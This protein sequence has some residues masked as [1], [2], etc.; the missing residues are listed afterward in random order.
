MP[1]ERKAGKITNL[2]ELWG[3][4]T[5]AILTEY[6][7]MTVAE[8]TRLRRELR[9][10]GTEYHVTKN[11]L[12]LRA[13]NQLGYTGLDEALAGPTAVAF[14]KED[15]AGGSKV[16]LDFARNNKTIVVKQAI[17]NGKLLQGDR[18]E[19]IS[20]IPPRAELISTMLGSL[21]APPRNLVNVL[22][23]PTRNLVNVLDA[24]RKQKEEAGAS[25]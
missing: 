19:A 20:K 12:L 24:I 22:S 10:K 16:I 23:Q 2:Q 13:A 21:L 5:L 3:G 18:L 1:T 25:A 9:P 11:T 6:R 14:I 15:V 4:S 17:L 8:L 7:G